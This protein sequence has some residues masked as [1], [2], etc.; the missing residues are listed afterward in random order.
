MS[1]E[2]QRHPRESPTGLQ[3]RLEEGWDLIEA[4]KARGE[5]T[6]A[7]E[8]HWIRLLEQLERLTWEEC[9]DE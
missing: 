9:G 8:R 5:D 4:A 2:T 1:S 7:L 6:R 3:R